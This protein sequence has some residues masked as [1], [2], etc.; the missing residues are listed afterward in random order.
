M[1]CNNE[2]KNFHILPSWRNNSLASTTTITGVIWW[3]GS[4]FYR[5]GRWNT[6]CTAPL[7][8][9]QRVNLA[10]LFLFFYFNCVTS[11]HPTSVNDMQGI[12]KVNTPFCLKWPVSKYLSNDVNVTTCADRGDFFVIP[13]RYNAVKSMDFCLFVLLCIILNWFLFC[14]VCFLIVK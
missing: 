1:S 7:N 8:I 11:L 13:F 3:F 4:S 2:K 12:L 5:V 14:F 6:D 9:G 10:I